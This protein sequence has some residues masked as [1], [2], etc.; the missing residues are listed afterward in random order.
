[1]PAS[2]QAGEFLAFKG[3]GNWKDQWLAV[4][5][6]EKPGPEPT[7]EPPPPPPFTVSPR[8][9]RF[10][11]KDRTRR[12]LPCEAH[13]TTARKRPRRMPSPKP[14][15]LR[16]EHWAGCLPN[17]TSSGQA[18]FGRARAKRFSSYTCAKGTLTNKDLINAISVFGFK[19]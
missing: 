4:M 12:P 14:K 13:S 19:V 1:M 7:P 17:A 18:L 6:P 10:R 3:Q 8:F 11:W 2:V 9:V 16:N 5:K 15:R